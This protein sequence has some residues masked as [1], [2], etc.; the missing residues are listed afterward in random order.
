MS[1]RRT[2]DEIDATSGPIA[3]FIRSQRKELGYTQEDFALRT[4]VGVRFLKDIERGKSTARM[5][6]VNQVLAYL[7]HE[8]AP[9]PVQPGATDD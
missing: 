8:L 5:D 6:K 7:G 3:R 2:L 1:T 9:V 4:G